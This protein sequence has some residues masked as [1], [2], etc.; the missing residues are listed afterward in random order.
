M[1][2]ENDIWYTLRDGSISAYTINQSGTRWVYDVIQNRRIKGSWLLMNGLFEL[3]KVINHQCV[4]FGRYISTTEF[5]RLR[6]RSKRNIRTVGSALWGISWETS[7][8]FAASRL[9]SWMTIEL[10]GQLIWSSTASPSKQRRSRQLWPTRLLLPVDSDPSDII[11]TLNRILETEPSA[12]T[13][14]QTVIV[15]YNYLYNEQLTISRCN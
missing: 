8:I 7:M 4:I 2:W 10:N 13:G 5:V 15:I 3:V 6:L 12:L 1:Q 11:R 14:L 9:R